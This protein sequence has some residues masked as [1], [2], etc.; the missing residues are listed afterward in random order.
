M[1][2]RKGLSPNGRRG[3]EELGRAEEVRIIIRIYCTRKESIFNETRKNKKFSKKVL[4]ADL[5]YLAHSWDL[6][7]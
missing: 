5:E 7:T 3:E 1:K 6:V 2:D 4:A